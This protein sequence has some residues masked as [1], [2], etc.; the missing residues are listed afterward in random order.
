MLKAA[1]GLC[2]SVTMEDDEE[3][4]PILLE[5]G[6]CGLRGTAFISPA[7]DL[8]Q[9]PEGFAVEQNRGLDHTFTC[10]KCGIEAMAL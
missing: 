1:P 3:D 9:A 8:M 2:H 6:N 7:G 4:R 10:R 5:C